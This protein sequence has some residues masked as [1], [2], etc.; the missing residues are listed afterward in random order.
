MSSRTPEEAP[1][2]IELSNDYMASRPLWGKYGGLHD[3]DFVP[4]EIDIQLKNWAARFEDYYDVE[5]GWQSIDQCRLQYEEGLRL[6][7]VL[8]EYFSS[9]AII[10]FDFWELRANGQDLTLKDVRRDNSETGR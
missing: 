7:G 2:E 6:V 4:A 3:R 8:Q 10:S 9:R 5:D 1:L